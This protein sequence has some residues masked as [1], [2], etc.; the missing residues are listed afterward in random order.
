[1]PRNQNPLP[2]SA[3]QGRSCQKTNLLKVVEQT[4]SARKAPRKSLH[5]HDLL[6]ASVGCHTRRGAETAKR[7]RIKIVISAHKQTQVFGLGHYPSVCQ[8]KLTVAKNVRHRD[9]HPKPFSWGSLYHQATKAQA[10]TS[11]T[12]VTNGATSM[13]RRSSQRST[14]LDKSGSDCDDSAVTLQQLCWSLNKVLR[15]ESGHISILF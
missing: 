11:A 13:R 2:H 8:L 5:G 4:S 15:C 7:A 9:T 10:T 1:M 6:I 3:Q 12:R 14:I